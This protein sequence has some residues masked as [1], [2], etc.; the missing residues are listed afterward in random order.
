MYSFYLTVS[1]P[2]HRDSYF[3]YKHLFSLVCAA[4]GHDAHSS[5]TNASTVQDSSE[6][7]NDDDHQ[8]RPPPQKKRRSNDCGEH[9]QVKSFI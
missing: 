3:H 5:T 8:E 7:S 4:R 2:Y 1:Y 9:K 6:E